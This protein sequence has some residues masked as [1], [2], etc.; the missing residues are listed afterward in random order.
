MTRQQIFLFIAT[1]E[2]ERIN[3]STRFYNRNLMLQ[4]DLP[5]QHHQNDEPTTLHSSSSEANKKMEDRLMISSVD[6]TP[7]IDEESKFTNEVNF[8]SDEGHIII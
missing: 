7:R 4:N 6:S 5:M 8:L 2:V 1:F 3:N